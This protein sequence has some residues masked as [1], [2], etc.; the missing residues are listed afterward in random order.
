MSTFD[1]KIIQDFDFIERM[2][3][4]YALSIE[5]AKKEVKEG[6][7]SKNMLSPFLEESR[8]SNTNGR[9]TLYELRN[10]RTS[11]SLIKVDPGRV[12]VI[13]GYNF[14]ISNFHLIIARGNNELGSCIQVTDP[15]YKDVHRCYK[16]EDSVYLIP[17]KDIKK[18]E[19]IFGEYK[20]D[21]Y[22]VRKSRSVK[23][24]AFNGACFG[25]M[26]GGPAGAVIGAS[27]FAEGAGEY[28]QAYLKRKNTYKLVIEFRDNEIF[29]IDNYWTTE[30]KENNKKK[31]M[32]NINSQ[33]A[34]LIS[35]NQNLTFEEKKSIVSKNIRSDGLRSFMAIILMVVIALFMFMLMLI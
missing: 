17:L 5:E 22:H 21:V 23:D 33:I 7:I 30:G 20:E 15:Y 18:F 14:L 9:G 16:N 26:I 3:N 11:D 32:E 10:F 35:Q 25:M 8:F 13:N 4:K 6:F 1:D 2:I 29:V 31:K 27:T 34:E 12:Y 24:Q 19:I 28:T